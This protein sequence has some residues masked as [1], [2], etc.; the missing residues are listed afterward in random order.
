M[1]KLTIFNRVGR[2]RQWLSIMGLALLP[3]LF[4]PAL[5]LADSPKQCNDCHPTEAE[6]WQT[7][8]HAQTAAVVICEDCHG[9]YV[10]DHPEK[11]IMQ[12]GVDSASCQ[13]CHPHTSEQW[14]NSKHGRAEVQC[15][16]CHLSHSQQF[17]LTDA[18]LCQ[19]CHR[20]QLHDFSHTVHTEADLTCTDCHLS[21]QTRSLSGRASLIALTGSGDP[22]NHNFQVTAQVCVD[23]HDKSMARSSFKSWQPE[24]PTD[25]PLSELS[26]QLKLSEQMNQA[27][28]GWSVATLGLGLGV[29]G[30]L[31]ILFVLITGRL[32]QRRAKV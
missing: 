23:C 1:F 2:A 30:M 21:R 10:K 26:T 3:V 25:N 20:Q 28:K 7:S 16:S 15:I 11:G 4:M 8:S 29:G 13:R 22:P 17:R 12:L 6:A 31:G 18:N 32:N 9:P 24:P 27:L 14:Q 19:S 5:T